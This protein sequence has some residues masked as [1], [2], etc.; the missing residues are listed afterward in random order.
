VPLAQDLPS[1][2]ARDALVTALESSDL[3]IRLRCGRALLALTDE[4]P[5]P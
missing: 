5:E 4:H 3:K 1:A 2:I